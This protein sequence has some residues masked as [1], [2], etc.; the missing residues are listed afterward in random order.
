MHWCFCVKVET[1]KALLPFSSEERPALNGKWRTPRG[2]IYV[3]DKVHSVVMTMFKM[4]HL[5]QNCHL[6]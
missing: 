5:R 4:S 1:F 6:K 3:D 2:N